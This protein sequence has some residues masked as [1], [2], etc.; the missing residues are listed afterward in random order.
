MD[1]TLRYS[2]D[3]INHKNSTLT[4][5]KFLWIYH[6]FHIM[7]WIS[8]CLKN[9]KPFNKWKYVLCKDEKFRWYTH[10]WHENGKSHKQGQVF[11]GFLWAHINL[12]SF[13]DNQFI[14]LSNTQLKV[15]GWNRKMKMEKKKHIQGFSF[16]VFFSVKLF[17]TE[18]K[19]HLDNLVIKI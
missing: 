17:K 18:K 8:L 13:E 1:L 4:I 7:P 2:A 16:W 10:E 19:I 3:L 6:F 11:E 5:P 9:L 15:W 12:E 14:M